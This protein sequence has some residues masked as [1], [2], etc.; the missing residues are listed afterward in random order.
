MYRVLSLALA[1]LALALFVGGV[2]L[3]ADQPAKPQTHEGTFVSVAGGKLV[4]KGTDSKE[5]SHEVAANAMITCDGKACKLA[6]LKVGDRIRVTMAASP[7]NT[8]SQVEAIEKN[9]AFSG[10]SD[11]PK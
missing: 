3:A 2:A 7:A 6:D 9:P 8:V 10:S 1:A 11:K 4:M 5:H